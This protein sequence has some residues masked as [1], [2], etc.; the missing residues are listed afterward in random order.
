MAK[1]AGIFFGG[2]GQFSQSGVNFGLIAFCTQTF[3][4]VELLLTAVQA[5]AVYN[6]F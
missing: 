1:V 2:L 5:R 4:F 6:Y 3:E